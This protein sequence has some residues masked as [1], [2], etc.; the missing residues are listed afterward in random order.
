MAEQQLVRRLG[1]VS[2]T[3]IVVSNMIGAGIFTLTGFLAGD[4]GSASAVI[5]IWFAGALVALV[6]ALCYAEL[7]ANFPRSG[8]EYV[9]LSEAW[10]PAWGFIDGW[11][12]F[13]AG[14]S[15]PI[16]VAA[17]GISAYLAYFNPALDP[18][19]ASGDVALGPLTLHLGGGE[20]LACGIVALFTVV[21]LF[22]VEEVGRLQNS[23]TALKL[24]V[25]TLLLV[26]G[27]GI[28][29]GDWAHFSQPAERTSDAALPAQF[30][31]SL[32]F[33]YWAYSG[34]NAAIYVAEEIREPEVTLPRS[35][36]IG[37]VLVAVFYAAL[38]VL[39]IYANPLEEM[40]GVIAVGSQAAQS[41]FGDGGGAWFSGGMAV[42]LLATVNAM[43]LIGPRVYYADGEGAGVLLV[44]GRGAPKVE[45]PVGGGCGAGRLLLSAD[46]HRV[47]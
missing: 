21:N 27:F 25:L 3:A 26:L 22:G 2:A 30:L 23:L 19:A 28:G 29:E 6:G 13:F 16:A 46:H 34:W 39:Y 12:T 37:T 33:V 42:S 40:K 45:E 20:L 38:N 8:G 11:V 47:L 43:C 1:L 18:V 41:L 17:I 5:G 44:R 31:I 14:F 10:G 35:L 32:I 7:G 4:L 15:A 9:Y 36:L 24:I